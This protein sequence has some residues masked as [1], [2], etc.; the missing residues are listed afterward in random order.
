MGCDRKREKMY[1]RTLKAK[2]GFYMFAVAALTLRSK[3]WWL[4]ERHPN[5]E[6]QWW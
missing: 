1:L 5:G 2:A 3:V 4:K 6:N